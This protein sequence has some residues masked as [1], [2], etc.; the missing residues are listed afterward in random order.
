TIHR[1]CLKDR[2]G[3][4]LDL[5]QLEKLGTADLNTLCSE[6]IIVMDLGDKTL[7]DRFEECRK[8]GQEGIPVKELVGYME[9]AAKALDYLNQP[10]DGPN[11]SRQ[12][13]YHCDIKP[14]NIL[15]VGGGIKVCD[16]GL[17][18]TNVDRTTTGGK[19]T[20]PFAP[21]PEVIRDKKPTKWSDQYS[22]ALTYY[23]LRSG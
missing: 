15:I 16:F 18:K 11:S 19:F 13:I 14:G 3:N 22:L 9:E 10:P 4:F 1:Y 12:P 5:N 6:M 23:Y 8:A 2:S 7:Q 21:G 20:V 17:V